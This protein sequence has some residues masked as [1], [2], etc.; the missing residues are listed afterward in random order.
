MSIFTG[1]GGLSSSIEGGEI[2]IYL[3][4]PWIIFTGIEQFS[5]IASERV[6]NRCYYIKNLYEEM[7]IFRDVAY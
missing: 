1:I 7:I 3:I 5:A 4:M 2:A 6:Q